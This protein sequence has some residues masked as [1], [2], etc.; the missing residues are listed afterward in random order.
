[1]REANY[2]ELLVPDLLVLFIYKFVGVSK[3]EQSGNDVTI[4]KLHEFLKILPFPYLTTVQIVI[5]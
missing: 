5:L 3:Y 1:M 4:R 2:F